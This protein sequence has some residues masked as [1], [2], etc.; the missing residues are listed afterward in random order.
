MSRSLGKPWLD[1]Y[2]E[3]TSNQE[4]P[5]MFHK[6]I[7]ISILSAAVGR[8]ISIPRIKYTVYPN[9]FVILVAG[10]A[11]CKKSTSISIGM[12]LLR[13]MKKPPTVFAQKV[14]TEALIQALELSKT[15]GSS[16]GI[17]CA[18]ELSVF[19][20][21]ESKSSGIILY[22]SPAEWTYHT[23][24]RGKE[25]LKNVTLGM[26]AG[27][28]K[29]WL[30]T[31]IPEEAIGGGFTSRIIF[32]LQEHPRP[33]DLFGNGFN[34]V[35]D[36]KLR[37]GLVNGLDNIRKSVKGCVEFTPDAK[38][39][40]RDWYDQE[41][42]E[43]RD[44]KLDGYYARK[45]DTMFKVAT[46]LSV[47]ERDDR[48]VEDVHIQ[49]ALQILAENEQKLE[50][51]LQSVSS[52]VSGSIAEK[53]LGIVQRSGKICHSELLRKC[54]RFSDAQELNLIIRTLVESGEVDEY[55][56]KGNARIYLPSTTST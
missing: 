53:V 2:L 39:L 24:G 13:S 50:Q 6:W 17:I 28:T 26:L 7:G 40:A 16:S 33:R 49:E 15:E 55:V 43:S 5:T 35:Y 30:K 27:T 36:Y 3:Y 44:P 31:S 45:H 22:D 10:S 37:L 18:S 20:G 21:N 32:V 47:S 54:W 1:S 19:L 29:E 9:L 38:K 51:I 41:L 48:V 34:H 23:R 4:S 12:D 52:S 46:I 8:N 11:K 56:D 42:M 14:T 25:K